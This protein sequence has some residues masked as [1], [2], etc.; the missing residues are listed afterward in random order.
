MTSELENPVDDLQ[1]GE[2]VFARTSST[3]LWGLGTIV[4]IEKLRNEVLIEWKEKKEDCLVPL[5]SEHIQSC[6]TK[7]KRKMK[8]ALDEQEDAY[9]EAVGLKRKA[10]TMPSSSSENQTRDSPIVERGP[11]ATASLL[12]T[13][14]RISDSTLRENLSVLKSFVSPK[15]FER[16]KSS[17]PSNVHPIPLTAQPPS[18][19]NVTMRDY[20]IAGV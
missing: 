3:H 10:R 17:P 19:V 2:S 13:I 11:S 14:E 1:P 16:I 6:S 15:V 4:N 12:K 9:R 8:I 20:Q 7:R 5:T 18:I